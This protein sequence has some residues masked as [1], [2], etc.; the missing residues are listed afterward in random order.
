MNFPERRA[1]DRFDSLAFLEP[2]TRIEFV[3]ISRALA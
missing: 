2:R 3:E 1:G